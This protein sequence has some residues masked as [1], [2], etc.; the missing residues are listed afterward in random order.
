[1]KNKNEKRKSFLR[2]LLP[3][4]VMV[5]AILTVRATLIDIYRVHGQSMVPTY[6]EGTLLL[7]YKVN[8]PLS[9]GDVIIIKSPD[10]GHIVKR[11]IGEPGDIIEGKNQM[12][13]RNGKA[14]E[15]NYL[16]SLEITSPY[17]FGP[18]ELSSQQYFVLGDNRDGSLDSRNFGPISRQQIVATIFK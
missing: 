1:M 5:V 15:E 6:S 4:A 12:I 10:Y 7:G 17:D 18:V 14:I 2:G 9:Y 16:P 13:Y 8:Q 3:Y 11:L